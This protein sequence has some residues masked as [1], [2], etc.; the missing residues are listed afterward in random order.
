MKILKISS[1]LLLT[2]TFN[3]SAYLT[4]NNTDE[5]FPENKQEYIGKMMVNGASGFLASYS[6][7]LLII[8]QDNNSTT[9]SVNNEISLNTLENAISML[10]E[11]KK[12]YSE[13]LISGEKSG[14]IKELQEKLI[15]YPYNNLV[16][17]ENMNPVIAAEVVSYLRNG[18]IIGLYKRNIERIDDI[19]GKLQ[20]LRTN[21]ISG[22]NN[23]DD[24]TWDILNSYSEAVLFGNYATILS[25]EAYGADTF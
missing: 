19:M 7:A 10:V 23:A 21:L 16:K 22:N 4:L 14:Y 1:I 13:A 9:S 17:S 12:F 24:L 18:D 15:A 20:C 8:N 2:L 3:L 5:V 25:R 11:S 6:S